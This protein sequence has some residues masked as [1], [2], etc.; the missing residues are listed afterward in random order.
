MHSTGGLA[1]RLAVLIHGVRPPYAISIAGEWGIGKVEVLGPN[2]TWLHP[3]VEAQ[4][5]G[6]AAGMSGE[7]RVELRQ[8]GRGERSQAAPPDLNVP[9]ALSCEPVGTNRWL[10]LA[11]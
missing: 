10:A 6:W 2:E 1:E 7:F 9:L 11:E 4:E 8:T 3:S 5:R